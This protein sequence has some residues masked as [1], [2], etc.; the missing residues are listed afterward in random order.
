M[1]RTHKDTLVGYVAS[2]WLR[3]KSL[4][5]HRRN[6]LVIAASSFGRVGKGAENWHFVHL[7]LNPLRILEM[8]VALLEFRCPFL[9]LR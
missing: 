1:P 4:S 8:L 3:P 2:I 5:V 9:P 7:G 6:G